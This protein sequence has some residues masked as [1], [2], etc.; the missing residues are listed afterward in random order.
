MGEN[1]GKFSKKPGGYRIE[2]LPET[3]NYEYIYKNDETLVKV[4]QYGIITAQ[5]NPP[6]DVRC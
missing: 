3:G 6:K 4:D 1:Y 2:K 5:I